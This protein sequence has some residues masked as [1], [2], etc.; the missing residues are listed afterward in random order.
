MLFDTFAWVE[1]FR[2]SKSGKKVAETLLKEKC[3]T[4]VISLG[5]L[6]EWCLKNNLEDKIEEYLNGIEKVS[7]I[8]EVNK[9][10]ALLAGKINNER[11]KKN[12]NWGMV[13]SIILATAVFAGIKILT[14]DIHFKDLENV[15]FLQ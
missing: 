15:E 6:V 2:G 8:L 12:K 11:K 5:E 13:D 10:I 14:G 4:S 7:V 1:F 9:E 3:F